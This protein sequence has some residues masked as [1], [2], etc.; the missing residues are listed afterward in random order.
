MVWAREIRCMK[1]T[2]WL[3]L[4]PTQTMESARRQRL[5]WG[6]DSLWMKLRRLTSSMIAT[7]GLKRGKTRWTWVRESE[8]AY[9]R[10]VTRL[11]KRKRHNWKTMTSS[12]S[13]RVNSP[14][15]LKMNLMGSASSHRPWPVRLS[16]WNEMKIENRKVSILRCSSYCLGARI[17]I[18]KRTK[19][20][21]VFYSWLLDSYF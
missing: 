6:L 5:A 13:N 16:C 9:L 4:Y 3:P 10:S 7:W 15:Y 12:F 21:D 19:N 18:F 8:R 14:L 1:T 17:N 2:L 20:Q 11:K